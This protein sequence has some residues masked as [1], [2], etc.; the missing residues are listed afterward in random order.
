MWD[1]QYNIADEDCFKTLIL[2]K[3]LKI[4]HRHQEEF[5]AISEF[6]RV[7]RSWMCK[8]QTSVSQSST[9]AEVISLGCRFTHGWDCR[10]RSLGFSDGSILFLTEPN[11]RHQRCTRAME[12]LVGSSS[13]THK[14]KQIPTTNTS[15]DLTILITFRQAEHILV[16]M[17][18]CMYLRIMKP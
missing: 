8:K 10:S 15:V 4:R 18:C 16:P 12:K 13:I 1:A 14:R 6:T 5:C 7:P 11:Q 9:E 17:S 3:T 2:Q